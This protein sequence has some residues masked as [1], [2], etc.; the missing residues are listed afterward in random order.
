[1]QFFSGVNIDFVGKRNYGYIF[2]ITLIAIG[3]I[4]LVLRGGPNY[5]VDFQ[6]G[7]SIRVQFPEE[8]TLDDVRNSLNSIGF[9][10]SELKE[11]RKDEDGIILE[12]FII[13]VPAIPGT[14]GVGDS[15]VAHF[16]SD[17]G[18]EVVILVVIAFIGTMIGVGINMGIVGIFF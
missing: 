18:Q 17:F 15:V 5:G 3:L 8:I 4:F 1:M 12:E 9:G 16:K 11:S 13:R 14:E 6:G 2:S 7:V 10:K